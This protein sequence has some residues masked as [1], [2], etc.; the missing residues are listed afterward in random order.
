MLDTER[1]T[2]LVVGDV[3]EVMKGDPKHDAS[4]DVPDGSMPTQLPLRDPMT[5]EVLA[6]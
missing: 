4:I 2:F 1:M 3:D 5:L 6:D